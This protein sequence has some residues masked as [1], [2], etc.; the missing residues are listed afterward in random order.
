MDRHISHASKR[1][2]QGLF[3]GF[4]IFIP[5]GVHDRPFHGPWIV[6]DSIRE[7]KSVF[8]EDHST[9][10]RFT[11]SVG[12]HLLITIRQQICFM[13]LTQFNRPGHRYTLRGKEIHRVY[14][15]LENEIVIKAEKAF[16]QIVNTMLTKLYAV[17]IKRGQMLR[18]RE[19]IHVLLGILIE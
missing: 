3:D 13:P 8:I 15:F 18:I 16:R 2:C 12:G 11:C 9:R 19:N 6:P 1:R 10:T 4:R 14:F 17:G 5:N 7:I